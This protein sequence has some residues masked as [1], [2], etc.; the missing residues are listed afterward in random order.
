MLRLVV[1]ISGGGSN[2]RALL[3]ASQDAEFPARV[4]AVGADRQAD[5]LAH[6]EHYGIPSFVVPFTSFDSR[7][8]WGDELLAQLREWQPDVVV[9]SGL[10]RLLPAQVVAEYAPAI[11]NTH[12]AYL[13][14]FPGAH[15]VRDALAAGV[16][17]TG[18]SVIVVDDGVDSGPILHQR[19][20][21]VEPGD[22]EATLHERIKPV[23]RELLI[24]TVLDLANGTIDLKEYR[25]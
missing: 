8:A 22:T 9:L 2:L 18:A 14:E 16:T 13:P 19:R 7:E 20:V 12:P 1:L 10:M 11:I 3:D 15:G 17:E 4:V 24:Q 5:G 21:P 23:E 25:A 6:A